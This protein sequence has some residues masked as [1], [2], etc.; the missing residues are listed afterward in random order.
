V[1]A[2]MLQTVVTGG[3][4]TATAT[5]AN[6]VEWMA[7]NPERRDY[8]REHPELIEN[9][10]EEFLRHFPPV[11]GIARNVVEDME[12]GGQLLKAGDR[13]MISFYAANH[14]PARFESPYEVR[15]ERANARDHLAYSVGIHRCLGAPL[16]RVE[17]RQIFTEVLRRMP[18]IR[19]DYAGAKRYDTIGMINGW[20]RMPVTFTPGVRSGRES[21]VTA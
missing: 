12:V 18:D 11:H 6:A 19:I 14:D 16:A 21:S 8:L 15:F 17:L 4:D 10:V 13:V 3:F 5:I 2:G 7:Q 1:A 9:A 20:I